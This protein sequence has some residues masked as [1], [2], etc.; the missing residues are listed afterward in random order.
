MRKGVSTVFTRSCPF[1]MV[2]LAFVGLTVLAQVPGSDRPNR[3][4]AKPEAVQYL[5]PEQITV[6]AG[7]T[8]PVAMHFRVAQGL[9]INSHAPK[10]EFLIPTELSIP[11]ASGVRLETADYPAG[12]EFELPVEPGTKLVVYTGDFTIQARIVAQPGDHMVEARLHYQ[13]CDQN[14]CLPPKT[15]TVPMDVIGK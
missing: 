10:D 14:A 13:A 9:H 12:T 7:K 4:G 3:S 2:A 1:G 6:P 15:I 8:T 5:Y 11:A